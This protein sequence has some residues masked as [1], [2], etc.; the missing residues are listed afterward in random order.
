MAPAAK[1][2]GEIAE[3]Q[4]AL[5]SLLTLGRR[6]PKE[7]SVGKRDVFRKIVSLTS[8]GMDMRCVTRGISCMV[9]AWVPLVRYRYRLWVHGTSKGAVMDSMGA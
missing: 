6:T 3:L 4:T 7:Q 8:V 2:R 1:P 9:P 5:Q